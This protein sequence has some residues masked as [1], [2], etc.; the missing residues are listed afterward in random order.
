MDRYTV[1]RD[2]GEGAFS[3][4]TLAINK[5]TG[6]KMKK[7]RWKDA[8][9]VA[10]ADAL[11]KLR[12]PHIVNLIEVFRD[13]YR[14]C[15]VFECMDCDLNELANTRKGKPFPDDFIFHVSRQV[16][17]G[18][19]YI[20]QLGF[21]HRDMKP[22]NILIRGSD[23]NT[24]EAKIADFGLVHDLDFSR[25]L[26]D[27]ISTRWYRA[28]EVLLNCHNYST[29][30]DVWAVGTIIA[31]MAMQHPLF[32]GNNQLDQLRRIF[33]VLGSPSSSSEENDS[34]HE[35]AMQAKKLGVTFVQK[36]P[37]PLT[38][39]MSS[40]SA[41]ITSLVAYIL[42]LNPARR[43]TAK[44]C[45]SLIASDPDQ[46]ITPV[47]Q[48]MTVEPIS[49]LPNSPRTFTKTPGNDKQKVHTVS[50]NKYGF[51]KKP[52]LGTSS[53]PIE[54][55]EPIV[56][57]SNSPSVTNK[58]LVS[59][60]NS[61]SSI[62]D[63]GTPNS[64]AYLQKSSKTSTQGPSWSFEVSG[65]PR[66]ESPNRSK[67][68]LSDFVR[69][70]SPPK[71]PSS[72]TDGDNRTRFISEALTKF[73]QSTENISAMIGPSPLMDKIKEFDNS[74]SSN[75]N[76][77]PVSNQL[78]SSLDDLVLNTKNDSL[79]E[80]DTQDLSDGEDRVVPSMGDNSPVS[81]DSEHVS[82]PESSTHNS[83]ALNRENKPKRLPLPS[84]YGV[85]SDSISPSHLTYQRT[86]SQKS[87][88]DDNFDIND[89][90]DD[91][92]NHG[93]SPY[94]DEY[95]QHKIPELEKY[96]PDLDLVQTKAESEAKVPSNTYS[97]YLNAV[98]TAKEKIWGRRRSATMGAIYTSSAATSSDNL[99]MYTHANA[100]E[101]VTGSI[102]L[103]RNSFSE[104]LGS[105]SPYYKD[106][107]PD[108]GHEILH[109]NLSSNQTHYLGSSNNATFPPG[110]QYDDNDDIYN[111]SLSQRRADNEYRT[112]GQRNV[113]RRPT[114]VKSRSMN[115]LSI[116]MS[117]D[118]DAISR[119]RVKK[120]R[121]LHP[122][123]IR[124]IIPQ[125]VVMS[126]VRSLHSS[127]RSNGVTYY[128]GQP[129]STSLPMFRA[130]IAAA[131]VKGQ[132]D[133]N[134]S[135][136]ND[137]GVVTFT[138]ISNQ[139]QTLSSDANNQVRRG[140][141]SP[142]SSHQN[143]PYISHGRQTSKEKH[144]SIGQKSTQN[145]QQPARFVRKPAQVKAL[146]PGNH[147]RK[148]SKN[149]PTVIIPN[150]GRKKPIINARQHRQSHPAVGE[151]ATLE[152]IYHRDSPHVDCSPR[153]PSHSSSH[154]RSATPNYKRSFESENFDSHGSIISVDQ[155]DT[156]S[157]ESPDLNKSDYDSLN[158]RFSWVEYMKPNSDADS[159]LRSEISR[160][161]NHG[162]SRGK[163]SG[164][165]DSELV[166][167]A[168]M[169][170][171][172]LKSSD[173]AFRSS[174]KAVNARPYL[175][176]SKGD[177]QSDN[178]IDPKG[179]IPK[180]KF[181]KQSRKPKPEEPE[182]VV[183]RRRKPFK[184]GS[185]K[186]DVNLARAS[187]NN[188]YMSIGYNYRYEDDVVDSESLSHFYK[189]KKE[190]DDEA[191]D[192]IGDLPDFEPVN[193]K[194]DSLIRVSIYERNRQK[195]R[196]EEMYASAKRNANLVNSK[197]GLIPFDPCDTDYVDVA[198]SLSS[199]NAPT[200]SKYTYLT[201]RVTRT[202]RPKASGPS[203]TQPS[204]RKYSG[205]SPAYMASRHLANSTN[206][207]ISG[208]P[209]KR[210]SKTQ[211]PS[212]S[213]YRSSYLPSISISH[214]FGDYLP[215]S[216]PA[217][218]PS[219]AD[220]YSARSGSHTLSSSADSP[221]KPS[222]LRR[223]STISS[224]GSGFR[225]SGYRLSHQ[226]H[227]NLGTLDESS[228]PPHS[229]GIHSNYPSVDNSKDTKDWLEKMSFFE[230]LEKS[231]FSENPEPQNT[232]SGSFSGMASGGGR[233]KHSPSIP[234]NFSNKYTL[235]GSV[236]HFERTNKFVSSNGNEASRMRRQRS[237][238]GVN[239]ADISH[240]VLV[241]SSSPRVLKD[242]KLKPILNPNQFAIPPF[243]SE[244]HNNSSVVSLSKPGNI[245]SSQS[246]DQ[247]RGS[248]RM[249]SS[250]VDSHILNK[251]SIPPRLDIEFSPLL[252]NSS[253]T[254]MFG[255]YN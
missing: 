213:G 113:T 243:S 239:K 24:M 127:G 79:F 109:K 146:S 1:V 201:N 177:P 47:S 36:N 38:K 125:S 42:C 72:S 228:I 31:E 43:P 208:S 153:K 164:Y 187:R 65:P 219:D 166:Y 93:V 123:M 11:K 8:A 244:F 179:S 126:D 39:V 250:K 212:R 224:N 247:V 21:F 152:N 158:Q 101:S 253:N 176:S 61:P 5:L 121:I 63:P 52:T 53:S 122:D 60:P 242:T 157:L 29:P 26:T 233:R 68:D 76:N 132:S 203:P 90:I 144:G 100:N 28:P 45:L 188:D 115:L 139:K 30:I 170:N 230:E 74:G 169:D 138:N 95:H 148:S 218:R 82:S 106:I 198:Q 195:S 234:S 217:R 16:L 2:I 184:A 149:K 97:S 199:P 173:S 70:P 98:N 37:R 141:P 163:K 221:K 87:S 110:Y 104:K 159:D 71:S 172:S 78:E 236:D 167:S 120:D 129:S 178:S 67:V 192:S 86:A 189:E 180:P 118:E 77:R 181:R 142:S 133:Q 27:Y 14:S 246:I 69:S 116:H 41:E 88:F 197:R 46:L 73:S 252:P 150:Y 7:R 94:R 209:G 237:K 165:D 134:P 117:D 254:A 64:P 215:P 207:F 231:E 85:V 145:Q 185:K 161:R 62:T 229:I 154:I 193:F 202:Y 249:V 32:P 51:S 50:T 168:S 223:S 15:L 3:S 111:A 4:V 128:R 105:D 175:T 17:S 9:A 33:D 18:L 40:V 186:V 83:N 22:E 55:P 99:H 241:A 96:S 107:F 140:P 191:E 227:N 147:N 183:T 136:M 240:P 171:I 92:N 174:S 130:R 80:L 216:S 155:T 108:Y 162:S 194:P 119:R 143:I 251:E 196:A 34:W 56:R 19:S 91:I 112:E 238:S 210:E 54:P 245:K 44:D 156:A 48:A 255:T 214:S 222:V 190:R 59:K 103:E 81:V 23:M 49:V 205:Q 102:D 12:H 35:G 204:T 206:A 235:Y 151:T 225:K 10:E 6:Q 248:Q 66:R 232:H 220:L 200:P 75:I 124:H 137:A 89:I 57:V 13:D 20:H 135:P 84:Y 182:P 131:R 226:Y 58:H 114:L 25:P 211:E 160:I